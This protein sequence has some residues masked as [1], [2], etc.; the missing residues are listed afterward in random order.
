MRELIYYN[1]KKILF[2][3]KVKRRIFMGWIK[4]SLF[5]KL[6]VGMLIASIIPFFVSNLISYQFNIQSVKRQIIDLN[7]HS[8]EIGMDS[9]KRYLADLTELAVSIYNEEQFIKY[10]QQP[11]QSAYE[12]LIITDQMNKLYAAH[13]ELEAVN[14]TT[15]LTQ[16]QF[17]L[18]NKRIPLVPVAFSVPIKDEGDWNEIKEFQVVQYGQERVLLLNKLLIDYPST[19]V[20]GMI[21]LY[22][23]LKEISR[24]MS[25]LSDSTDESAEFLIIHHDPQVLYRSD[26]KDAY[27]DDTELTSLVTQMQDEHGFINGNWKG[28]KGVFIYVSDR[29]RQLPLTFVRFVPDSTIN[30]AANQTLNHSLFIQFIAVGFIILF[31][32]LL[33]YYFILRIKRLLHYISKVQTGN[34]RTDQKKRYDDELGIVE[35]RFQNMIRQLDVLIN[36]EYRHRLELS[37]AQLKMLQSQINPHF[38]NNTL[39]SISTIALSYG[40]REINDKIAELGEL[41]R[42]SMDLKTEEVNLQTE[43]RHIENYLSLQGGRFQNKLSYSITCPPELLGIRMPKMIFQPLVENSIVHGIEKGKGSGTIH[44][45]IQKEDCIHI[46]I[47][48]NGKGIST[49]MINQ[50][51]Q[52]FISQSIHSDSSI[53][54]LNVLHRL[55]L[56]YGENF[57]WEIESESYKTTILSLYIP[58]S[59]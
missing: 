56:Y 46:R 37:T 39:Q 1:G 11:D 55:K 29:F 44:I 45:M 18:N 6:L 54:L 28:N 30:K 7:S 14:F 9:I 8:M 53:G 21:S 52:Q 32:V 15:S 58:I 41:F 43:L 50:L 23:G 10:V 24:I 57:A 5:A 49:A 3:F 13:L 17:T 33:S 4:R 25:G 12:T 42:Y 22:V 31:T 20:Y 47:I 27:E 51:K 19:N 2:Q 16:K 59:S 48:D 36:Q 40:A 35:H 34:F 38:L 26:S